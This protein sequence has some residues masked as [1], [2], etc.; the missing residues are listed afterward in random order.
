MS[1]FQRP[2]SITA[3]LLALTFS[4][5][6]HAEEHA[7]WSYNDHAGTGPAH[8]GALDRDSR[9][10]KTG[11]QQSPIALYTR[12]AKRLSDREIALH[13]GTAKGELVNNGHTIQFNVAD[14]TT[15]AVAYKG[16]SY[17]L[18]QFH[19][20]TPSEH[21]LD[22]KS[23]PMEMHLVNKD[24]SG[25]ITVVGVFIKQG[26]KNAALPGLWDQLPAP[27]AAPKAGEVDLAALLPASHKAMVY[28]GSLTTPPC[29]EEVNWIVMEQPIEMS[30]QQI[31]AFQK[32]FRD[33]HRPLQKEHGRKVLEESAM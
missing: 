24:A 29:S 14:A 5:R 15:N 20:H 26:R 3:A 13:F 12:S 4:L 17:A 6:A 23:F 9:L 7:H 18:A 11:L 21:R 27:N 31:Q 8:W 1:C 32:L 10:C 28:A 2:A 19:F 30:R 22:G 16:V 25:K 33:N